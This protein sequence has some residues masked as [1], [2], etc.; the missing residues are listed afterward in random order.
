MP[1]PADPE[2][3]L[4]ETYGAGWRTP[5][6]SFKYETPAWL[7]RRL[8]GWF[9][10]LSSNRKHWDG[11]YH[12][13]WAKVPKEPSDFA[14]W[15]ADEYPSHRPLVDVGSGTGRDALWFARRH[16]REV[17]GLDYSMG[18]MT[19]AN[20]MGRQRDLTAHFEVFNL[21]DTRAVLTMGAQLSRAPVPV[22][23]YARFL[24]HALEPHGQENL[25][26][27]ASMALRRGGLLFL[28]F[29]TPKDQRRPHAFGEYP[30]NY[31]SAKAAEAMVRRAGGRVIH[32]QSGVGLAILGDE[33]PYVCRMVAT[34]SE[35]APEP[36]SRTIGPR[37]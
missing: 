1:A 16:R 26:R 35:T 7:R 36:R 11:F 24:L 31:L 2:R 15:V 23:L 9:G 37:R 17:T 19:R 28:E 3:L 30:R 25:M 12:S 27:L 29:R 4:A 22:D 32:R 10:G 34:W 14:R 8:N 13:S 21:Y 5:D 20:R 18:V 6:P 33:D